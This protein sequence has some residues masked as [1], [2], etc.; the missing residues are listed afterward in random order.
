MME[1]GAYLLA[2]LLALYF[3]LALGFVGFGLMLAGPRGARQL[4]AVLFWWPV[5][6]LAWGLGR[7]LRRLLAGIGRGIGRLLAILWHGLI[8]GLTLL[9]LRPLWRGLAWLTR[10]RRHLLITLVVVFVLAAVAVALAGE[11]QARSPHATVA[12][13]QHRSL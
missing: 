10:S 8:A 2:H 7:R 11:A 4:A 5:Q 13:M 12:N 1:Q 3:C 6:R 9:V